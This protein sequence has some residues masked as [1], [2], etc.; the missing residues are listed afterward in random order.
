VVS[1]VPTQKEVGK[2]GHILLLLAIVVFS[3]TLS[4]NGAGGG[5]APSGSEFTLDGNLTTREIILASTTITD[6]KH[7]FTFNASLTP[8]GECS[9]CHN[10]RIGEPFLWT[11]NLTEEEAYFNQ[12]SNPNYVVSPTIYCYDCHDNHETVDNNPDY[13][14]FINESLGRYIPQDAAFDGNMTGNTLTYDSSPSDNESGYYETIPPNTAPPTD[15]S[16]TSGHYIKSN[17]SGLMNINQGDKVPCTDCH[18]PHNSEPTNEVFLRGSAYFPLGGKV[19]S[20]LKASTKTRSGTGTGRTICVNCHGNSDAGQSVRFVDINEDYGSTERIVQTP[21]G[22]SAHAS[23]ENSS[24]SPC[25]SHD[26]PV[27][28]GGDGCEDCHGHDAGYGGVTGGAGTYFSHSTH[29]E[30]DSDDLKG[31]NINCSD[32]H[33]IGSYPDFADNAT[34]LAA[35]TVCDN[36]HSPNGSFDGVNDEAIGAK[37]NWE[38]GVYESEDLKVGKEQWCV[39]CHD[40]DPSTIADVNAPDVGGNDST[41]GYFSTGHGRTGKVLC[42]DCHNVTAPHVDGDARTYGF[43]SSYY[44]PGQSGVAYAAGYR[45][46]YVGGAVP[47]MIPAN[48]GTTFSYNAQTMKDNAFRLCFDCHDSSKILDD[49]PGDGID[50]NFKASL[51]NPPRDYSYAW[52]SGADT[53]EHV[54]HLM[55]YV[56]PFG[57]SDW[58]TS[59]TGTGGSDGRDSLHACSNCHNVH[60]AAGTHGSTNEVMIRDGR[61]A[62]RTGYGFSYVLEDVGSGGYPWVT[63]SG[64]TQAISNGSIFR[65]N[66]ANMCGGPMCHGDP[67]PPVGSSY[68]TSGSSWGTYLEYYRPPILLEYWLSPTAIHC[69]N[70]SN[71]SALIDNS[72]TTGNTLDT[73]TDQYVVFDLGGCY[74]V[75]SIKMYT[76][77]NSYTWNVSMGNDTG[78]PS[79]CNYS[80][81]GATVLENWATPYVGWNETNLS[82][83]TTARYLKLMRSDGSGDLNASSLF[84]FMFDPPEAKLTYELHSYADLHIYDP[85]GRHVGM[86]YDTGELENQ[87]PGAICSFG[88]V[89]TVSLPKLAVGEYKVILKGTGTGDYELVVTGESEG[90]KLISATFEGTITEDEIHDATTEVN[91]AEIGNITI[92]VDEPLEPTVQTVGVDN[93]TLAGLYPAIDKVEVERITIEDVNTASMPK[94][95]LVHSVYMIDTTGSGEFVLRFDDVETAEDVTAVYKIAH[96]GSWILLPSTVNGSTVEVT[97]GA[98]D[99]PVVFAY[100][101]QSEPTPTPTPTPPPAAGGGGPGGPLPAYLLPSP[102]PTELNEEGDTA[103]TKSKPNFNFMSPGVTW[104]PTATPS[105]T[106]TPMPTAS[107]TSPSDRIP[108][109]EWL[110]AVAGLFAVTY[111]LRRKG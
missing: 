89:Q 1:K 90:A 107:R 75:T 84:E 78:D 60:G 52:G 10:I 67:T 110:F 19:V 38:E 39:G 97:L 102:T 14:F 35:T 59:T 93:V 56:G 23:T 96:D 64:A 111:L 31:P 77:G 51:P 49:T 2:K 21:S 74:T 108:G 95:V 36:C 98:G 27:H 82:T 8:K 86:N 88:E 85:A 87:I 50:S 46:K 68:N 106:A 12:T 11:R 54:A 43:N 34:T 17:P 62:G 109:F 6:S 26:A 61:L 32:C 53:N 83:P 66:T 5:D 9:A 101:V 81:W 57:D 79:C 103:T 92:T 65:N 69:S 22:V 70:L 13:R 55:N 48:Y 91:T 45:L 105:L 37:T 99:P 25:H 16:S 15:G 24:C 94:V 29:T 58:D 42:A 71:A 47:L 18:E 3:F 104:T 40:S 76:D 33:D 41:Y 30:N 63:S 80:N 72:T 73:G 20:N 100:A 4:V 44:D 7:D 28:G